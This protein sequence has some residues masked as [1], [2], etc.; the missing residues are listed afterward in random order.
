MVTDGSCDA[1][2]LNWAALRY[3]HTAAVGAV[4]SEK[5]ATTANKMLSALRGVLKTSLRLELMDVYDYTR[6]VDIAICSCVLDFT[7]ILIQMRSK[8]AR[9]ET[10]RNISFVL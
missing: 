8:G 7:L 1:L 10:N 9:R 5:Y 6:A 3:K 2:T 4:M